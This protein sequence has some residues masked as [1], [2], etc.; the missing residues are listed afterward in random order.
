MEY[1]DHAPRDEEGIQFRFEDVNGHAKSIFLDYSKKLL[2]HGR[3]HD[4][5][6]D[7]IKTA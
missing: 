7:A 3:E 4:M 2:E 5:Y 6:A 1:Y